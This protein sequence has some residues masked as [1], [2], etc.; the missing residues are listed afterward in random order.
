VTEKFIVDASVLGTE[1]HLLVSDEGFAWRETIEDGVWH[2]SNGIKLSSKKCLNSLLTLNGIELKSRIHEKFEKMATTLGFTNVHPRWGSMIPVREHK[3]FLENITT[4]IR[5]TIGTLDKVYHDGTW[6]KGNEVLNSFKSSKINV[7]RWKYYE[8]RSNGHAVVTSFKPGAGGWLIP[9]TYNR[10]GQ[11]TGRMTVTSGPQITHLP[12]GMRGIIS[13]RFEGGKVMIIDFAN[14]EPRI[15]L[16]EAGKSCN[17]IDLYQRINDERYGG[18]KDRELLKGS[19]IAELY[20]MGKFTLAKKMNIS[21][22]DAVDFMT[23]MREYFCSRQLTEKVH[24][25]YVQSGFIKNKHGR[26][27]EINDPLPHILLNS[28][29]QATGVDVA[30]LGFREFL[31]RVKQEEKKIVPLYL[32]VDALV[33]DV[34]PTAFDWLNLEQKIRVDGYDSEFFMTVKPFVNV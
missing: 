11:R 18:A 8:T 15:V 33:V 22:T 24:K 16:Y 2:L 23:A 21:V 6:C 4:E 29:V 13:S 27:I 3:N 30:L 25:Q 5:G 7:T 19:V 26:R 28:Y 34:H 10:F 14:L 1:K 32:I 9:P 31:Q 20:G 17:V 12:K